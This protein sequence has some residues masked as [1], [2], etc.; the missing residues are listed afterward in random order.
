MRRVGRNIRARISRLINRP[1]LGV[2]QRAQSP[3]M[4]QRPN[5]SA[6][7][8]MDREHVQE[9]DQWRNNAIRM[10]ETVHEE[11]GSALRSIKNQLRVQVQHGEG[12]AV[13]MMKQQSVFRDFLYGF[14][15]EAKDLH[16][17]AKV[18]QA[19]EDERRLEVKVSKFIKELA[20]MMDM[21]KNQGDQGIK[22]A[23]ML[24]HVIT[25]LSRLGHTSASTIGIRY[26]QHIGSSREMHHQI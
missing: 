14:V 22:N 26:G 11:L 10:L 8:L 1:R 13:G 19:P 15:Q 4:S 6:V 25:E 2:S 3:A 16:Y 24:D 18:I 17:Q 20:E 12:H 9:T 7:S 5:M 21:E 23:R